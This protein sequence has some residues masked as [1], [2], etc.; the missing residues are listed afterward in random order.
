MEYKTDGDMS[1]KEYWGKHCTYIA[2]DRHW[3]IQEGDQY[4]FETCATLRQYDDY[5][6]KV[7]GHLDMSI[8][9][10]TPASILRAVSEV[11]KE[12]PS[13][14]LRASRYIAAR[15]AI[16]SKIQSSWVEK[17]PDVEV[18]SVS[19]CFSRSMVSLIAR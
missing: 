16:K 11:A 6:K 2:K 5:I 1:L 17:Q 4:S 15:I 9:E 13:Y 12:L 8:S 18:H 3:A 19:G 14:Q 7:A 10:I